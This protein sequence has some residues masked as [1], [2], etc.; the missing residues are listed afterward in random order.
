MN[1]AS[2]NGPYYPSPVASLFP[3]DVPSQDDPRPV[4]DPEPNGP[5]RRPDPDDFPN[6]GPEPAGPDN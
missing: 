2:I 3:P 4:P 1:T 5:D 6:P